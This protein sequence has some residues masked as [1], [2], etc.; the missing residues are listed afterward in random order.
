[1]LIQEKIRQA[2]Q[3]LKEFNID[4][5]ITFTRESQING[6]PTL[7]FLSL[8][9]VTWHSVFIITKTGK[10]IAI[11]GRY[12]QKMLEDLNA[13]DQVISYVQSVK[14]PLLENLKKIAPK[15][16]ALNYSIGSEISD[17]ITHGM[18]LTMTNYLSELGYKGKIIAAEKITSALRER[19]AKSEIEN[20]KAAIK[21]TLQIFNLVTK[22]IQPGKTEKQI[23]DFMKAEV[24][25][26]KLGYAWDE[27]VCP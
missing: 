8:A 10:A 16:I 9:D 14:E 11:V 23:A 21:H 3:L 5:W 17:G 2:K 20:I 19:K 6:D 13:Y 7:H 15:Q 24:N 18:Y 26:R 22:Y 25:K 12:D 27:N 1:M 4:C